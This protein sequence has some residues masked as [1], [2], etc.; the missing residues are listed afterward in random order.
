MYVHIYIYIYLYVCIIYVVSYKLIY[1]FICWGYPGGLNIA[2]SLTAAVFHLC[3]CCIIEA[4][5]FFK[6]GSQEKP[7]EIHLSM[8]PARKKTEQKSTFPKVF[9]GYPFARVGLPLLQ[10]YVEQICALKGCAASLH[11]FSFFKSQ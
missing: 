9:I 7:E 1:L 11:R 6:G 4:K 3:S 2:P 5:P 8:V 10:G